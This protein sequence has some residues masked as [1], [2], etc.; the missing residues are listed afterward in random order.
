MTETRPI[1]FYNAWMNDD[2]SSYSHG[3]WITFEDMQIAALKAALSVCSCTDDFGTKIIYVDELQD[4]ISQLEI[5][6]ENLKKN[7]Q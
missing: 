5:Q 3:S 7:K 1:D 6:S 4:L 2:A